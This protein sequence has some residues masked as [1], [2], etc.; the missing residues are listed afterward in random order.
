ME[1]EEIW[2]TIEGYEGIY[3][4]SNLGRVKSETH[5]CKGRLGSGR[6]NGRILK[7]CKWG[8]GYLKVS[9]MLNKVRFTTS[10]HRLVA[11]A[12][13]PN[14]LNKPQVNHINGIKTDKRVENLEWCTNQENILHYIE[15]L[16]K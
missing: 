10:P 14:P 16:K 15:Y 5:Y 6:Q 11:K 12:F 3:K 4:V 13:I 2:K 8:K 9:L 1:M 7:P